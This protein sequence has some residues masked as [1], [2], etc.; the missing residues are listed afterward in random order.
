VTI[1]STRDGDRVAVLGAGGVGGLLAAA[2]ARTGIAV[3]ILASHSTSRAIAERG[4][5]VESQRFGDFQVSVRTAP[6][7]EGP[8]SACLVAVKNTQLSA[9]LERVPRT[10][11]GGGLVVPFLNGIE[12][13]DRLRSMYTPS[14]VAAATFRVEAAKVEAGLIRHTSPFALINIAASDA[15][16]ARVERV[17]AQLEA[18]GFD[19]TVRGDETS[20][21]WE[22]LCFLAAL[23]LVTTHERANAGEV[24]SRRRDDTVAVIRETA[25]VAVAEGAVVDPEAMTHFL[26]SVPATMESSMQ[27]DQAAGR[28]LELD[29]IGGAVVRRARRAGIDVPVTARLVAE[30]EARS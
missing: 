24:R 7:L 1:S 23:A 22:K 2:L 21:L 5:R 20:M 11:V 17:A 15:N 6:V 19:V 8:V 16:R 14:A 30:L 18:A 3:E 29:A 10:A 26:D 4:L 27:R 13:V 9:A 12:H 25:A 28:P